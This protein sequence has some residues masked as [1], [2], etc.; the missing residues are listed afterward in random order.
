MCCVLKYVCR[1][2]V[3]MDS[4]KCFSWLADEQDLTG[5]TDRFQFHNEIR[6]QHEPIM[7]KSLAPTHLAI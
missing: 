4:T 5:L 1:D 7:M 3:K 6:Y 2:K